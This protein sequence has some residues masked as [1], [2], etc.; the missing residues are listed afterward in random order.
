MCGIYGIIN[1][2][3]NNSL[4][5][6]NSIIQF[7]RGPDNT[8]NYQDNYV[9][10]SHQ[11]LSIVDPDPRSHQPMIKDDLVITFN[12]EIY[13]FKEIK[14]E[15]SGQYHFETNSD[16]EVILAAWHKW[17]PKCLSK[18][19][20]MFCFSIYNK[21]TQEAWLVRD[22][23]GIKPL[24]YYPL[25]SG[26]IV[27]S[28]E[29]KTLE[30]AHIDSF[31][32]NETAVA[33]SLLYVWVPE[34]ICIWNQVKKLQPGNFITIKKDGSF[35]ESSYWNSNSL[36][37]KDR[38]IISNEDQ[39]IDELDRTLLKS[40]QSHLISDVPINAFL[41]GGLDS[42]LIVAMARS[43]LDSL[44]CYTIK[45]S[46]NEKKTESMSDDAHYAKKVAR[47]LDVHLNTIEVN[48]DIST[49]LP[50]I[51]HHLDEPIGDSA[52]IAT[53]LICEA[54]R[55]QGV[56]VLLSGMG[57]DEIFGG[58]RKHQANLFAQQY[59][60]I[61]SILTR[62]AES[63]I[64]KL[65]V[66]IAGKG[67]IPVRWAKR[68][69]S[70]ANLS[71][72]DAFFR[73][74]TYYDK[75]A[76]L[77]LLPHIGS[78][79]FDALRNHHHDFFNT[80]RRHNLLDKMCYTDLNMFM[81]SLNQT[82]TDRASMAAS[83]EVRVPFIDK[84]VVDLAFRISPSLKIK[85][86]QSK[87]ILKKVAEKWLPKD[88]IYRPKSPFTLPIRSWVRY[89]LADMINDYILSSSGLAGRQWFNKA[90]LLKLVNDDRAGKADN[91]QHIWQL[92][93][94]EQWFKNHGI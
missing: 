72:E 45:F 14:Q 91:A 6:F 56:K 34:N 83:T 74:Y 73:S 92:L 33:A 93:T 65:P 2:A 51:V 60:S 40:V 13:N 77:E 57:A 59:R 84:E 25:P 70:F 5:S 17:G 43:E 4:D 32:L 15:L 78:P 64:S 89:Q 11:R 16:T 94:L 88:I 61:P 18:L 69:L 31:S 48:P 26:G 22:P 49:L 81:V 9:S 54:A 58:Y 24:F 46:D 80:A 52:A 67:L 7:H 63:L 10:L 75:D 30:S 28:S 47:H 55:E 8:G 35:N 42:S 71:E 41:S 23:F 37:S 27:F 3:F 44:D 53:L 19:R 62:P 76:F 39:A 1:A 66:N 85:N 79:A 90:A 38:V 12:G 29:L 50:K 87:Y 21:C 86:R 36:L 20:G 82:Y 68:F